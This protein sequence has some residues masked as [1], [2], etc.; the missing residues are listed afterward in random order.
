MSR[1][2]NVVLRTEELLHDGISAP[3]VV[4]IHSVSCNSE[5]WGGVSGGVKQKFPWVC[6]ATR[7]LTSKRCL[8]SLN[9]F[10]ISVSTDLLKSYK[11]RI[12]TQMSF[13]L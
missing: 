3:S 11:Q 9:Y 4:V 2:V 7:W 6:T 12:C 1:V 8:D 10:M 5:S 13:L